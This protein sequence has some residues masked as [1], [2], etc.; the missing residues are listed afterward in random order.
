MR[1]GIRLAWQVWWGARAVMVTGCAGVR[2][3]MA[4]VTVALPPGR[5]GGGA[6]EDLACGGGHDGGGLPGVET[7]EGHVHG[8]DAGQ[9]ATVVATTAGQILGPAPPPPPAAAGAGGGGGGGGR[10]AENASKAAGVSKADFLT[11]FCK[12]MGILSGRW[13]SMDEV[14]DTVT[15]LASDRAKYI[16]GAKIVIDAGMSANPRPA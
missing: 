7:G 12:R 3:L 11:A 15:F 2:W 9:A 1:A 6:G 10:W 14:A 13:A 5:G 4:I 8:H 16:N